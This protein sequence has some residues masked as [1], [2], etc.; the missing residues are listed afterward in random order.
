MNLSE[1]ILYCR[2]KAGLSQE[3]LAGIL[4]VSSQSISK[5]E[6]GTS[7]PEVD[8]LLLLA[9]TFGVSTDWL[10]SE[11]EPSQD[12][13]SNKRDSDVTGSEPPADSRSFDYRNL[14]KFIASLARKYGWLAGVYIAISGAIIVGSG[15][16]VR[17][18]TRLILR[19]VIN[20]VTNIAR[21]A[22]HIFITIIFVMGGI[23][24][25]SGTVLAFVLKKKAKDKRQDG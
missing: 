12:I 25:V 22:M 17:A 18:I 7:T 14:P 8:K 13:P 10:L 5:W 11:D 1:K 24:I 15:F 4:R 6:T 23:G 9:K 2:Q 19:D 3:E 21:P 20:E 16:L